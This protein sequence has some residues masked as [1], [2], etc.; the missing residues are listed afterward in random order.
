MCLIFRRVH[1]LKGV[2]FPEGFSDSATGDLLTSEGV[3]YRY[4]HHVPS[5]AGIDYQRDLRCVHYS[6]TFTALDCERWCRAF[7]Y[8]ILFS[9][10]RL[11]RSLGRCPIHRSFVLRQFEKPF[12]ECTDT[13]SPDWEAKVKSS[14]FEPVS[15]FWTRE[16]KSHRVAG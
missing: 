7:G 11:I 8:V 10:A 3:D 13:W 4:G 5:T 15:K 1:H 9:A 2:R 6:R 16:E 14:K 12:I